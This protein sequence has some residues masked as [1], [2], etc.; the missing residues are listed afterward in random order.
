MV[1]HVVG[2]GDRHGENILFDCKTGDAVH[3][4]F[5]CL[6][7]KGL[8][9]ELPERVPFRLTQNLIDGLGVGGYEGVFM[10]VC[11]IT[12]TVLRSHR[13]ALMSVLE[14]F[15]HDPLVEWT[16]SSSRDPRGRAASSSTRGKDALE[17]IRSRLEGVVVGVGA[18]PSLPLSPQGQARRLVEE[19]VS[20]SNLGSMYIWWM[21][22]H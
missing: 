1:G 21:A 10:R 14:T 19:A 5:A 22:W 16:R 4:D 2:L 7:D 15:V 13:E 8:E 12:L 11:E 6:F 9:L 3:V 18:A 17:K 20:L